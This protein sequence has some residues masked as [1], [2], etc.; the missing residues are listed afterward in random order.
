M[1]HSHSI[2][3]NPGQLTGVIA[4]SAAIGAITAMLVTP[5]T[6]DQVRGGMKRRAMMM[7][8]KMRDRKEDMTE[9]MQDKAEEIKD[10]AA[11][12]KQRTRKTA[13][14]LKDEADD[15]RRNGER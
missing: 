8:D 13:Q 3:E 15:I 9:T 1:A 4:L 6:G 2:T 12:A 7:K 10:S 5:R 11:T 14:Q